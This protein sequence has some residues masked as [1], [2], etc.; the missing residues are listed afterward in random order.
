[1]IPQ[2]WY[3]QSLNHRYFS[4]IR[5]HPF[6]NRNKADALVKKLLVRILASKGSETGIDITINHKTSKGGRSLYSSLSCTRHSYQLRKQ[7]CACLMQRSGCCVLLTVLG[8]KNTL[9][10]F[11]CDIYK[12]KS[13]CSPAL[14][15]LDVSRY[16]F[17]QE[18][19]HFQ[20]VVL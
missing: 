2:C 11:V 8:E 1:M 14:I 10:D 13:S 12:T 7:S 15:Y 3:K 19:R 5:T 6:L 20:E 18:L 16:I 17:R 4:L 9:S